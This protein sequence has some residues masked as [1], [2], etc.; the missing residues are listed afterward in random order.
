MQW[1]VFGP[2]WKGCAAASPH[3]S[4]I[5]IRYIM[6]APPRYAS[7]GRHNIPYAKQ[8]RPQHTPSSLLRFAPLRTG[9]VMCLLPPA[10]PLAGG[11]GGRC[12]PYPASYLLSVPY[13]P[14]R[15]ALLT[16]GLMHTPPFAALRSHEPP[17][18]Y[19][20][21]KG[22]TVILKSCGY[23]LSDRYTFSD[24]A[25]IDEAIFS[26]NIA[27]LECSTYLRPRK[28]LHSFSIQR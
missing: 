2:G 1:Q 9:G 27:F 16:A 5:S 7:T 4:C 26:W 25:S 15:I 14:N 8:C 19:T 24:A 23:L 13:G 6:P 3:Q 28:C 11:Q 20:C 12:S 21:L 10:V 17:K 18:T 22:G